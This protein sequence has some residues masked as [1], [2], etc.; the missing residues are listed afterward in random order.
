MSTRAWFY[1]ERGQQQGPFPDAQFRD[2]IARGIIRPDTLIWTDGM[3]GW[4]SAGD[5]PGL[6]SAAGR[7][8]PMPGRTPV[9]GG[10]G[11]G[12]L[13]IDLPLWPFFGRCV[14]LAFGSLLVIPSPFTGT[15]YYQWITPR[16]HVPG[17]PNLAFEGKV[18]DIWWVFILLALTSYVGRI[19]G[20]LQLLG[21]VA[22][23]YFS[24][25]LLRWVLSRL[26][27]NG[28][29]LG[30][31]FNGSV[32]AFIG[33][34]LLMTLSLLTIVGWAWVATAWLRWI[35]A[36]ISGSRRELTFSG[37]GLEML[38]RTFAMVVGCVLL[39]PIPWVIRW[40]TEW[41]VS[42]MALVERDAYTNA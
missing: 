12:P 25:M 23:A 16:F 33:W 39:I 42:H 28:Q 30:L 8:P 11:S 24:W 19:H 22:Q 32:W 2:L 36:N 27:S 38:W 26:S 40:Y 9:A 15:G 35:C 14:L 29:L 37:T 20:S 17:R 3:A 13:S 31:Q 1:A 5:I 6:F 4:Q 10:A 7:P 41:A 18:G 34:Q 21:F